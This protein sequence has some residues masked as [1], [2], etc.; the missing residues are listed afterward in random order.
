MRV[1]CLGSLG[2]NA[3]PQG[4]DK[5]IDQLASVIP[6]TNGT[7]RTALDT[8]VGLQAGGH[9]FGVEMLLPCRLLL[10]IH[11][12]TGSI[13]SGKRRGCHWRSWDHKNAYPSRSFDMA[14]CSR[15]LIPWEQMVNGMY[16]KE[17]ECLR[18]GGYWYFQVHQSIGGTITN[19]GSVP[20]RNFRRNSKRLRMLPNF[21]AGRRN[22]RKGNCH[23][24]KRVNDEACHGSEMILVSAR[25]GKLMM[26][27]FK[28]GF[29]QLR[30]V[31]LCHSYLVNCTRRCLIPAGIRMSMLRIYITGLAVQENGCMCYTLSRWVSFP[32]T[33]GHM[34]SFIPMVFSFVPGQMYLE[35]ILLEMDRILRPEGAVII[36]RGRVVIKVKKI[37]AGMPHSDRPWGAD[38]ET[39][40]HDLSCRALVDVRF[41]TYGSAI[42]GVDETAPR[43]RK[44]YRFMPMIEIFKLAVTNFK[45]YIFYLEFSVPTVRVQYGFILTVWSAG[46]GSNILEEKVLDFYY[47]ETLGAVL[48]TPFGRKEIE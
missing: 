1:M 14:H 33:Q 41:P 10:E 15:C 22:M 23:L 9:T 8:G 30:P 25:L 12:S 26:S 35:D 37:T 39:L 48:I 27:V 16:M 21:F 44:R 17:V 38:L 36:V 3:V 31:H 24:A 6:I 18:P 7:V 32:H 28:L 34:I 42:K 45:V 47:F 2:R 46:M 29:N 4:A 43:K 11:M 40:C 19:H 13:C 20:R 5:Y